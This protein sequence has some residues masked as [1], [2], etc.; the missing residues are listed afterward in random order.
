[1][2]VPRNAGLPPTNGKTEATA[3]PAQRPPPEASR[4]TLVE[5]AS[6]PGAARTA[7]EAVDD[8]L[9]DIKYCEQCRFDLALVATELVTNAVEYGTPLETIRLELTLHAHEANISVHNQGEGI[10]MANLRK[11]SPNRGR[12]LDLVAALAQ[13]WIIESTPTSATVSASIALSTLT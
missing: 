4:H 2:D 6:A 12:G 11:S 1:M 7:R 5:L 10:D 3:H 13:R 8:L 9:A